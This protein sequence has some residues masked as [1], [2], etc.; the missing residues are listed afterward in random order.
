VAGLSCAG[1]EG[2]RRG[3]D[4]L[5]RCDEMVSKLGLFSA[6]ESKEDVSTTN[7]KYLLVCPLSSL[8]CLY[9]LYLYLKFLLN[10]SVSYLDFASF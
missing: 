5:R 9:C 8:P 7:L 10:H 1:Q 3:V 4:L 6:N 2:I